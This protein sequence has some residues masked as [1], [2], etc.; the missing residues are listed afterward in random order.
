MRHNRKG[1]KLSR[2]NTHRRAMLRNMVTSLFEHE[3]IETTV[4]KAKEARPVAERLITRA[5]RGDLAARRLIS[6]YVR[7]ETVA[8]KLMEDIAP[9][10]ATRPG[11]YTR[12]YRLGPR[13]GDAGQMG[14][15]ELV[16]RKIVKP[17]KKDGVAPKKKTK[18]EAPAEDEDEEDDKAAAKGKAKTAKPAKAKAGAAKPAAKKAA[19]K[20]KPE[21]KEKPLKD[22][23]AEKRRAGAE[24]SRTKSAVHSKPT[25]AGRKAGGSSK[26]GG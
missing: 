17:A 16:E 21:K 10:F 3:R 14:I 7:S 19:A 15:L 20:P 26:S 2:T 13:I 23:A 12:I 11:G 25:Q 18:G 4:A 22:D 8:R 24:K 5:R 1:R 6:A 9:R